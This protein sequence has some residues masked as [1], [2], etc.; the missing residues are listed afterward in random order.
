MSFA[1][2]FIEKDPTLAERPLGVWSL[3]YDGFE[4]EQQGLREALCALGNG[5][6]V[7][8]GALPEAQADGV[9]YPGTYVAG[10]YNRLPTEIAGRTIE[11]EDLVNL[12]N[13]LALSFQVDEGP[14][15]D[16]RTAD[17]LDHHLEL[18]LRRGVL[19]RQLRWQEPD[20]RRTRMVQRRF[21]S[22]K[23]PHLAGLETTFTAENW[24]G[25]L[26]VRSGVDGRITNSGVKRYH[27]LASR[28]LEI[29]HAAADRWPDHRIAGGDHSVPRPDRGRGP[30]QAAGRRRPGGSHPA[31]GR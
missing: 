6:F 11:N 3:D 27:G 2:D 19:T 28:H 20:G 26:N 29:L 5:Y 1:D 30:D 14:W 7:T 23:D 9:N 22:M 25:T 15:F 18:D 31:P 8:R 4:P 24:S 21:V 10:L 13:W 17:V 12:P 16:I